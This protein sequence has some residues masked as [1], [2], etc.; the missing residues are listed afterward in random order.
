MQAIITKFLPATNFKGSRIKA[1]CE[2]GSIT[3]SADS[4]LSGEH[5]HIAAVNALVAKFV[6]EDKAR[7]GD[8]R[9]PWQCVRACG[10]LPNGD[11]AHVAADPEKQVIVEFPNHDEKTRFKTYLKDIQA[12]TSTVTGLSAGL[13]CSSLRHVLI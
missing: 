9:N 8:E 1:I 12:T 2:R 7:Y 4:A 6:K 13:G 10:Q 11:Y 5:A 3:I